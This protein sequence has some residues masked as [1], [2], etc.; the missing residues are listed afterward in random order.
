MSEL[1]Y[2]WREGDGKGR[3]YPVA[4]DQYFHRRGGKFVK[5]VSG[6]VTLCASADTQIMGWAVTPKDDEGKNAWK[7]SSTAGKDK[8]F[9][10]TNLDNVFA[11]PVD[12]RTASIAES[13]IGRGAGLYNT[14]ATYATIQKVWLSST[15][16][17]PLSIVD[18][19]TDNKIAYVKIKP[20][21]KQ[22][23]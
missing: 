11:C 9:V 5:L 1:R 7:S 21:H 13:L 12:E 16:A 8:V 18:V 10:I 19:D 22:A 15:N 2:G 20:T 6:R 23:I 4:A 14:G 3:E 17:T